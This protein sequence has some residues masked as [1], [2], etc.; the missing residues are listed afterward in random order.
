MKLLL[1]I[2]LLL[3]AAVAVAAV[4]SRLR[5]RQ[6]A[7]PE[8][9]LPVRPTPLPTEEAPALAAAEADDLAVVSGIGPVFRSR[10]AEAG[11]T[12]FARL[13]AADPAAVVDATGVTPRRAA[14]WIAQ[15]TALA[16]R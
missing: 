3:I 14:D 12:T 13:A 9:G 16:G 1:R 5:E 11:I 7:G 8:A 10:L 15:A 6:A 4:L 2:A